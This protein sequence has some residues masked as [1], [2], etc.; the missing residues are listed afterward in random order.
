MA[1]AA[2]SLIGQ[3]RPDFMAGGAALGQGGVPSFKGEPGLRG[4]VEIRRVERPDVDVDAL[5]LLVAGFAITGDLAM[6]ALFRGDPVGNRPVAG[7]TA[8]RLDSFPVDVAFPAVRLALECA[9]RPGQLS[10]RGELSLTAM[11]RRTEQ[12]D[13][14]QAAEAGDKGQERSAGRPV[15][16]G[17]I[18]G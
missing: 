11:D 10:G 14:E 3:V 1:E 5:V 8:R 15:P 7:Q 9:V 16:A 6:D 13:E 12:G 17:N 18:P 4:M 2:V